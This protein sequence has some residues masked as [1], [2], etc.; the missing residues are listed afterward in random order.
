MSGSK[1]RLI[2]VVAI[3]IVIIAIG[4][5]A[6]YVVL[7]SSTTTTTS[8]A[9]TTTPSETKTSFSSITGTS[10]SAT[11]TYTPSSSNFSSSWLTYHRDLARD[12]YD[13]DEPSVSAPSLVW[14]SHTLDGAIYAEPLIDGGLVYIVTENN[15][16]YALNEATG[17]VIWRTNLGTPVPGNTLPCGD[18]DPSGITS[19]PVIDPA[20]GEIFVV[21]YVYPAPLQHHILFALNLKSGSVVFQRMVDPPGVSTFVEQ[22]RGAL[23]L[24]DGTIYIPYGGLDGDCGQYHGY[25]LGVHE[26]NSSATLTYQ[27]PT[28]REGG[29]WAPSGVAIDST[30]VFAATGNSAAGSVFDFGNAVIHLSFG[31]NETDYFAPSSWAGL[32]ANDT[33]LGSLGPTI[34]GNSTIFQIG[35]QGIGYLLNE[36]KLGGIGGEEFSLKVC[37]EAFGGTAYVSMVIYVPCT[38]GLFALKVEGSAFSILWNNT[39]FYAGSPIVVGGAVW[40]ID[41]DAAMI[42]AVSM[43][44][45]TEIFSYPLGSEVHFVTPSAADGL[46]FA[47]GDNSVYAFSI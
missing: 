45:G 32:N 43:F 28:G 19:T 38:N 11:T 18:I 27:A 46:V 47:T 34:L 36:S 35:K 40:T 8:S 4:L 14:Q 13:P 1:F 24:T 7:S 33:D 9:T 21:A 44:N 12:G 22:Q 17:E 37:N 31:L 26:D 20:V 10:S 23:S 29:I 30:G 2:F 5:A 41:T 25:V 6:A 42:H 15:S 39:R 16:V 3:V